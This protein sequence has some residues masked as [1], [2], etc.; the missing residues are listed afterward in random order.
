[1]LIKTKFQIGD[2]VRT[3]E[4]MKSQYRDKTPYEIADIWVWVGKKEPDIP[5]IHYSLER[6][7]ML[8]GVLTKESELTLEGV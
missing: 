7:E 2:K 6:Y 8:L 4:E 5:E 1:M 3:A